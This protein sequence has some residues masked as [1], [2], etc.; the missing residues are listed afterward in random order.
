MRINTDSKK[1]KEVLLRR[2][3]DIIVKQDLERKLASGKRLRIK[4]G[5][6]FSRPDIHLGHTVPL[7]KLQEFQELGHKIVF[8]VG[9]FTSRIGDPS[10]KSKTR[11]Q[12]SKEQVNRNARTYLEQASRVIDIKKVEVRRNSEW[13]DQM[14]PDDFIR[15]FSKIT[16]ARILERD[17]FE[18]RLKNKIN[19]YPHEIIYPILQAYDS[20]VIKADVELGG[21]DQIFNMLMGR[22]LQKRFGNIPQ[23]VITVPLLIG[24]DGRDK[25]SKSLDNYIGITESPQQQYG[26]I[27]SIPD[28]LIISYFEL[29]TDV[30]LKEIARM[31]RSLKLKRINPKKLKMRLAKEIVSAYHNKKAAEKAEKEFN[32]IFKEKKLPLKIPKIKIKEKSLNIL[33]L[34][35]KLKLVSSKS[36]AKRLILQKGIRIESEIQKDWEKE[37]KIKKGMII[38]KGKRG[39][40]KLV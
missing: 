8:I 33:D 15:L 4:F 13:Y 27:M 1:I 2:V 35:V 14:K 10:G 23:D 3:E 39:F 31:K 38:Q 18:K 16:L 40:V 24:L 11:P 12:L 9:D 20:I 29:L 37:I 28:N 34:L 17:D 19:I 21:T 6:D 5:V 30:S 32:R 7:K 25:M 26:K 36:E 22:I